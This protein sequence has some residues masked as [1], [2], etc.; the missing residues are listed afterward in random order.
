MKEGD[1]ELGNL[2]PDSV[3]SWEIGRG[4]QIYTRETLYDYINGGA[5]LYLSYGF[6]RSLS[7]L[8]RM[9]G[10]PDIIV[11]LFEMENPQSAFGV[12][13]HS[14]ETIEADF[15]QGSQYTP[16]FLTFWK[17]RYLASIL[18]S[19]ETPN[20]RGAVLQ[21]AVAIDSAIVGEGSLPRILA[22]LPQEGLAEPSIRYFRHH[23]WLNSHYFV[24]DEN[25]L[26]IDQ[27]TEAV[28]AKYKGEGTGHLLLL[29]QYR[30][31][32]DAQVAY[33]RF[34]SSFIPERV[35]QPAVQLEDGRWATSELIAKLVVVVLNAPTESEARDAL[36]EVRVHINQ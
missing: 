17:D 13:T 32:T 4:D 11:D 12:F 1:S 25:I 5:E 18:A 8:Y 30:E 16:G 23:V 7:R 26:N 21:I 2:L 20:S 28:L 29:V 36:E 34:V 33:E 6:K 10:E 15:G 14:R 35:R 3:G 31:E 19:P 27:D 9:A 22:L 24:S